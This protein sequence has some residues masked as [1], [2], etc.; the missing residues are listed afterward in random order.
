M[1]FR[2][3]SSKRNIHNMLS[4]DRKSVLIY[5]KKMINYKFKWMYIL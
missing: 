3:R 1:V 2:P 5:C 4:T